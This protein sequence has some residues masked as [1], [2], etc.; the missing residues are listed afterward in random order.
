[1]IKD[2]LIDFVNTLSN[3]DI[4][5]IITALAPRL[6][7]WEVHDG[8]SYLNDVEDATLNGACV[9]IN[10]K[11]RYASPEKADELT[12][13]QLYLTLTQQF[14]DDLWHCS[15]T[16]DGLVEIQFYVKEDK[17]EEI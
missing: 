10:P 13:V 12:R 3:E 14:H 6:C 2:D 1:M 11:H 8:V 4:G 15:R 9:Q 16:E 7:V 17:N 5:E